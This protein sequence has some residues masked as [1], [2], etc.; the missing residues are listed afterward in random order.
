MWGSRRQEATLW[1][2]SPADGNLGLLGRRKDA[3]SPVAALSQISPASPP[4]PHV[5]HHLSTKVL[6]SH[7]A[8]YTCGWVLYCSSSLIHTPNFGPLSNLKPPIID[9]FVKVD[10]SF[11]PLKLAKH[12]LLVW[13]GP[14][15]RSWFFPLHLP[16]PSPH[17]YNYIKINWEEY[18]VY[19]CIGHVVKKKRIL[20]KTKLTTWPS[21][22]ARLGGRLG[23]ARSTG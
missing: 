17:L 15:T 1:S 18:L 12:T 11:R 8:S 4:R 23:R 14:Q 21:F 13:S 10:I 7:S 5:S 3:S 19:K 6:N 16:P 9:N 22:Q 2:P 20:E